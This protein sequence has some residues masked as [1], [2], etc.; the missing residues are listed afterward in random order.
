MA[1]LS[2][3]HITVSIS[4]SVFYKPFKIYF[5]VFSRLSKLSQLRDLS[6]SIN[7]LSEG[8]PG[9]IAELDRLES[10]WL[11]KCQLKDLPDRSVKCT[12]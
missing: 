9:V 1:N 2:I 6:L 5:A 4:K 3:T 11:Y 7:N 8:L 10:L 12:S